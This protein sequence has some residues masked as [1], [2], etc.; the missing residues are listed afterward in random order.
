MLPGYEVEMLIAE[1]GMGAVYK[2]RQ[3][4]LDRDVA[5]KILPRELGADPEFR[6]SFQNEARAMARLNHSNLISVF[7]SG[8]AGGLL[9]L[10]ME[11]VRGKSLFHSAHNRAIDPAQAVTI[12]IGIC[13]GLAHAHDHGIIHRDVKPANILLT[14]YREP[15]LGDFGLARAAGPDSRGLAMGTPGYTAPEVVQQPDHADRR[16]DI[17]AAGVIFYELLTGRSPEKDGPPPS[18]VAGSDPALDPIWRTA[19]DP[20]PAS[21]YPSAEAMASALEMWQNASPEPDQGAG[22]RR[23]RMAASGTSPNWTLAR[24][25]VIIAALLLAIAFTWK[26]YQRAEAGRIAANSAVVPSPPEPVAPAPAPPPPPAPDPEPEI[27]VAP[28]PETD[29]VPAPPADPAPA[30]VESAARSLLRLRP[31][32]VAGER[33]EMPVGS[34]A[35]GRSDFFYVSFPMTWRDAARFAD[36]F[37]G[38]LPIVT[39]AADVEWLASRI[40]AS[41]HPD[42]STHWIGA[43]HSPG[44]G[45]QS[46]DASPWPLEM[47]PQGE[48]DL[49]AVGRDGQVIAATDAATHP[50]LIQWQR[51]GS[52]PAGL[53]EI[54]KRTAASL[55]SGAP[56]FPHGTLTEGERHLLVVSREVTATEARELAET[57]GG[58]LMVPSTAGEADALEDR[59]AKTSAPGGLWLGA[60]RD[61]FE[62]KWQTGEPWTFARWAPDAPSGDGTALAIVPGSGWKDADPSSTASGFIIEWSDE[63]PAAIVPSEGET[64]AELRAKA[65]EFVATLEAE[66]QDDLAANAKAFAWGLDVW[67]RG[68]SK[69]DITRWKPTVEF[70]KERVR[71]HRVPSKVPV[72]RKNRPPERMVKIVRDAAK[73]QE[74][75]DEAFLEKAGKLRD[76]Y[77]ERL[78]VIRDAEWERGQ[79]DLARELARII[80]AAADT[81]G[82]TESFEAVARNARLQRPKITVLSAIYGT[83]GKDANV[84]KRVTQLVEKDG[85]DFWVNPGE[86]GADPYPGWNKGLTITFEIDGEKHRKSWGENS[87]VKLS[88]LTGG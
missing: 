23:R 63:A 2:G 50:F 19:T 38:H 28:E 80:R 88:A 31:E 72:D 36:S 35:R 56:V 87:Q 69:G 71:V 66:R 59:I 79:A 67:L 68:N 60:S 54:L 52:N 55:A 62:W 64:A 65:E 34:V 83:R 33:D 82:W 46:V 41:S 7:D 1:G 40:P 76:S 22:R 48:G 45:W 16:S 26:K 44:Q 11:F 21:R 14:P 32:L 70:L 4:S 57:G 10:V 5:I 42:K 81:R 29:P 73:K 53:R 75:I 86:L 39:S 37:G 30:P 6:R 20:D 18:K 74:S 27:A 61:G 9:Y 51:D 85:R 43:R 25:L 58:H 8:D 78:T 3:R 77:V 49:A 12:V 84:T 24:N 47:I 17:F 13:R 15:K